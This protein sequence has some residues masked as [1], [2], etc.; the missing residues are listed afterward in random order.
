PE[1][2][3]EGS[4]NFDEQSSD[5]QGGQHL[6]TDNKQDKSP[7]NDRIQRAD[8]IRQDASEDVDRRPRDAHNILAV[9]MEIKYEKYKSVTENGAAFGNVDEKYTTFIS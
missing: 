8:E 5:E 3:E 4:N 2:E 9:I 7:L 6:D 1:I